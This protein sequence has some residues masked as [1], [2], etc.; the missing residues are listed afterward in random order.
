[1]EGREGANRGDPKKSC[2]SIRSR[3]A[4]GRGGNTR[5]EEDGRVVMVLAPNLQLRKEFNLQASGGDGQARV[6]RQRGLFSS[7][8]KRGEF[9]GRKRGGRSTKFHLAYLAKII[10]CSRDVSRKN[11]GLRG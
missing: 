7:K 6:K 4:R 9:G 2:R 10:K 8:G 11:R 1:V 5:V 3:D